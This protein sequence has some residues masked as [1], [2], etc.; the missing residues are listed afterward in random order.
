MNVSSSFNYTF[1]LLAEADLELLCTWF[2]K[3]HVKE[4]WHDKL[5]HDEIKEKYRQRIGETII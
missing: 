4:W 2:D 5:T 3:P 1:N